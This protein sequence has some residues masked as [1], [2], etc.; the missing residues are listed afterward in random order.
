MIRKL[1]AVYVLVAF[2]L[3]TLPLMPVQWVLNQFGA[4]YARTFPHWYH[5]QV[6]KIMGI[7]LQIEGEVERGRPVLLVA[8]HVSWV[9]ITVLSA[10][11]PISFV[12][13]KEVAGWPFIGWLAK[14]QR[15]VFVDRERRTKVKQTTG[16]IAKRLQEGDTMVLF[17]EGTSSDGNSVLPFKSALFASVD[18]AIGADTSDT[19]LAK[20]DVK[21]PCVQ[22]LAVAYTK[23]FGLPLGRRGRPY[24]AWYGD[25]DMADH[26]WSLLQRGP[27]NVRVKVGEP[28]LLSDF[29]SRKE[30]AKKSELQVRED[31]LA[32]LYRRG[33]AA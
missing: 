26:M 30:L 23:Q 32:L 10:V 21:E 11:A 16:A 31:V 22:T 1:R 6:C 15:T 13:K 14:L 7:R 25:M 24:I 9:D 33:K 18:S 19:D 4:K 27:I 28:V 12:A 2:M 20:S 29:E 8:N 5:R 3:F 17:A